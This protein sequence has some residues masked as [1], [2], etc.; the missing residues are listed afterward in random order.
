[1]QS[2]RLHERERNAKNE[3]V[4]N[5]WMRKWLKLKP[6]SS[7]TMK[8]F[9]L[10]QQGP[11]TKM[12]KIKMHF[13]WEIHS[14]K[15]ILFFYQP[16]KLCILFQTHFSLSKNQ[17]FSAKLVCLDREMFQST[18]VSQNYFEIIFCM[19]DINNGVGA[20]YHKRQISHAKYQCFCMLQCF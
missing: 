5:S 17:Y 1:M 4:N 7:K 19:Q 6:F 15:T 11:L 14:S 8:W 13:C 10:F 20:K 12:H 2:T 16:S 9:K 18:N 3:T